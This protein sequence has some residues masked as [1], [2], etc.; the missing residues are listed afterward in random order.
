[1]HGCLLLKDDVG[2][3]FAVRQ[4]HLD[5]RCVA[6]SLVELTERDRTRGAIGPNRVNLGI[7]NSHCYAHVG[8]MRGNAVFTDAQHGVSAVEALERVTA[9]ARLSAV[10]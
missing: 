3:Q 10:A 5:V 1:M 9:G 8:W 2:D 6:R 4:R 7:E